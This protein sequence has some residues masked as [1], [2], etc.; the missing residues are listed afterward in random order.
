M[1]NLKEQ[2]TDDM[3][4]REIVAET[5]RSETLI[6]PS[7][8]DIRDHFEQKYGASP[9]S[10]RSPSSLTKASQLPGLFPLS[11]QW[12]SS[13][14]TSI[15]PMITNRVMN[16]YIHNKINEQTPVLQ[17]CKLLEPLELGFSMKVKNQIKKQKIHPELVKFRSRQNTQ[18]NQLP[19]GM[20]M[21]V[22]RDED[23]IRKLDEFRGGTCR[24]LP[25]I[26]E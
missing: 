22:E 23:K 9:R 20:D 2:V 21:S 10:I 14:P 7:S 11:Q 17:K 3:L 26:L 16:T 4:K 12:S 5:N 24:N 6:I 1:M 19:I 15:H 18:V 25:M 8:R 13:S